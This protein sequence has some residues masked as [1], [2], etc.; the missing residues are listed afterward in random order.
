[1]AVERNSHGKKS[2]NQQDQ[3]KKIMH[4][5]C[6]MHPKSKHTLF[7]CISLRKSLNAPLSDQDEKGK[8]KDEEEGDKSE[9]RNIKIPRMS[10]ILS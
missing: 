8:D 3:F 4:K 10:S 1:M 6:S 2:E 7:Q 5:Q 9:P